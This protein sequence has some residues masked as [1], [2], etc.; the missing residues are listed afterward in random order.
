MARVVHGLEFVTAAEVCRVAAASDVTTAHRTVTFRSPSPLTDVLALRSADDVFALCGTLESVA[1]TRD[2]LTRV[3]EQVRR[4]DVSPCCRCVEEVRE[5][6]SELG[7]E[8]VASFVGRRNY[9]RYELE[10]VAGRTI[11]ATTGLAQRDSRERLMPRP[12]LSF[13][14]HLDHET[15]FLA[16]RLAGAPLWQRPYKLG[17]V[18]GSLHPPV[19][20]AL[21]S[22]AEVGAGQVLLDPF[23][24]AGSI[25]IEAALAEPRLLALASELDAAAI[26]LTVENAERAG[27]AVI[28]LRSDAGRLPLPSE[29]IDRVVSNLPW[30]RQVAY[31]GLLSQ[32]LSR[33]WGELAR[34]LR[35]G[36]RA[37]ALGVAAGQQ[38]G[39]EA[40][41]LERSVLTRLSLFG[42]WA[43]V[44]LLR[45]RS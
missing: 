39:I 18:P 40:V 4:I 3:G 2:A 21:C 33:L 19:A 24:G 15:G 25:P 41:G 32:D 26:R 1:Q 10:A 28:A 34:V 38:A 43:E 12:A 9:T 22:L 5:V 23:A 45:K 8:V 31:S 44:S 27:A 42:S 11:A 16:L 13:R 37:V 36:G 17:S 20:Y 35:S 30:M 14:L 29:S 6:P 7:F